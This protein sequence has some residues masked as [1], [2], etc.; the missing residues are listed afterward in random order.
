MK[1]VV[2]AVLSTG[3]GVWETTVVLCGRL[4]LLKMA[5]V[6]CPIPHAHLQWDLATLP[7]GSGV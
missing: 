3:L 1:Q 6:T 2:R 4:Y 7:S 5:I